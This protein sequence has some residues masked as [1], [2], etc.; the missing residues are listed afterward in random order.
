[1]EASCH[2]LDHPT[3]LQYEILALWLLQQDAP[4]EL[5]HRVNAYSD[6]YSVFYTPE[7]SYKASVACCIS[8]QL[9]PDTNPGSLRTK[10]LTSRTYSIFHVLYTFEPGQAYTRPS[11]QGYKSLVEYYVARLFLTSDLQLCT[12]SSHMDN[13]KRAIQ[14]YKEAHN[15][16][17]FLHEEELHG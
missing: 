7:T 9:T 12:Y 2:Q 13:P 16:L 4:Y 6:A 1:M 14:Y 5:L 11:L 8:V 17:Q 10:L 15:V 3:S